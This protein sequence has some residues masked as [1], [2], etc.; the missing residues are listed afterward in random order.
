MSKYNKIQI[1]GW[2]VYTG[3][4]QYKPSRVGK[5]SKFVDYTGFR[6]IKKD[7]R[8]DV[9]SQC[10]DIEARVAFT[11]R[12]I[13]IAYDN[14]QAKE[15][16]LK[17]FI[18][19]EFLY[20]GA[21]GAYLHDLLNG[22]EKEAPRKYGLS[23][24]FNKQWKG[25]FGKLQEI[26]SDSKYK[27]WMFVFG[28][29][30][31]AAFKTKIIEGKCVINVDSPVDV[32]NTSLIT[33]GGGLPN[34]SRV[35]S[36]HLISN[37]DFLDYRLATDCYSNRS[38]VSPDPSVI[39]PKNATGN[40][41]REP[42]FNFETV[43]RNNDEIIQFGMEICLDHCGY[44]YY[45]NS[46]GFLQNKM[47]GRLK[48]NNLEVDIQ[49]VPSAGMS[50]MGNSLAL[51]ETKD[52][53]NRFA[54]N[55]DG[56]SYYNISKKRNERGSHIQLIKKQG[57]DINIEIDHGTNFQSIPDNAYKVDERVD[58]DDKFT[59]NALNLWCCRE[60]Y[61]FNESNYPYGSGYVCVFDEYNL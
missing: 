22:W 52:K 47:T 21:S 17:I 12:A 40:I 20:R 29:A 16:V 54:V 45:K 48:D 57:M 38:I 58:I 56:L 59:I 18:A 46:K 32:Y 13:E 4:T 39:I 41:E 1:V 50:L 35:V 26:V 14:V 23:S 55:C 43:R 33:L 31:S 9:E 60:A 7:R 61:E 10:M 51:K 28:T 8:L 42:I 27:N 37:I 11:K 5:V 2:E 53:L 25:L 44:K 6:N 36:K 15:D 34:S 19:P 24:K 49:I 3:P 30:I